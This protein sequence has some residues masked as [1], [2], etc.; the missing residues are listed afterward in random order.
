MQA[1]RWTATYPIVPGLGNLHGRLAFN[2]TYFLYAALLGAGPWAGRV[3]HV[4]NGL[5]LLPLIAQLTLLTFGRGEGLSKEKKVWP[6]SRLLAVLLLA[7]VLEQ[8]L[9]VNISSPSPDMPVFILGAVL[10]IGLLPLLGALVPGESAAAAEDAPAPALITRLALLGFVCPTVKLNLL[11]LGLLA[12]VAGLAAWWWR[13][14]PAFAELRRLIFKLAALFAVAILPWLG[15]DVLLSGW[16]GFP[17][18]WLPVPVAWRMPRADVDIR[19]Q[20]GEF[21][22]TESSYKYVPRDVNGLLQSCGFRP[23][24]RWIDRDDR[25]ALTLAEAF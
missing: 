4:A 5:L 10:M 7:P 22:W 9:Q 25:F 17:A 12:P 23:T 13:R 11:V 16:L 2:Q 1:I 19:L 21:I 6:V 14:R 15:R 20:P 24:A 18:P 8:T 3:G